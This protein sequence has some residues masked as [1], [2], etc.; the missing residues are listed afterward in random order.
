MSSKTIQFDPTETITDGQFTASTGIVNQDTRGQIIENVDGEN[1]VVSLSFGFTPEIVPIEEDF[2]RIGSE[3]KISNCFEGPLVKL[4]WDS[5]GNHHLSTTNRINCENSYWGNREEKFGPLFYENGGQ[6]F[7]DWERKYEWGATHHFMIM[8]NDLKVTTEIDLQDNECVVVY[9][10]SMDN[11]LGDF[12]MMTFNT[13]IF[14]QQLYSEIPKKEHMKDNILYPRVI[15]TVVDPMLVGKMM[16][17]LAFGFNKDSTEIF[18]NL[19]EDEKMR[20]VDMRLIKSYFG[21]PMIVRNDFGITKF[22]P[23][24]YPKKYEILGNSPNIKLLVFNLMDSCRPKRDLVMEYFENYDFFF[25]PSLNFIKDLKTSDNPKR[26]IIM[27]YRE[28]G[29]IGFM[30]A[31]NPM[32]TRC[33]ERNLMMVLMLCLPESKIPKAIEGYESFL[34]CQEKLRDFIKINL[35][36]LVEGKYDSVLENQKVI[37]RIKDMCTRSDDYARKNSSV[38]TNDYRKKLDFS[39]NGLVQNERGGSLYKIDKALQKLN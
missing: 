34:A 4:W 31:K 3:D 6:K 30:D 25:V 33:R 20:G 28:Y 36:K 32:T 17:T 14:T 5:E 13:E 16:Q 27:K 10:G 26:D 9:L 35:G 37:F 2:R 1:K 29:T 7:I 24:G 21:S 15:T 23:E 19:T 38:H 18:Q 8:T 39:L 22:I 12:K 11:E